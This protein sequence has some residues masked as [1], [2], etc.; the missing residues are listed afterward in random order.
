MKKVFRGGRVLRQGKIEPADLWVY[1]EKI[2]TPQ[3]HADQIVDVQGLILAPGYIDLQ[4]NGGFGVDFS[5][6]PERVLEV[7]QKLPR[8]GVTAFLPTVISSSSDCYPGLLNHLR[9]AM[10]Q[11][12]KKSATALGIHLEG[13]FFNPS[14]SGAHDPQCLQRCERGI[15]A[16]YGSLEDVKMI[17]LAPELEGAL[18]LITALHA[19][20]IL[21]SA[22]HSSA[23][24]IQLDEAIVAG[25]GCATHLYNAMPPFHHRDPGLVGAV[26][27]HP[28]LPFTL[29]A[30]SVHVHPLA[31][32][33]AWRCRPEG[34]ILI[35]DAISAL[36]A[37]A[38]RLGTLEIEVI[39]SK[40]V[41]RGTN[42]LA[43]STHAL[44]SCV[45]FFWESTGCSQAAALE[46]AS[47]KP[48]KLL[49]LAP[50]K[51]TLEQGADAD[52][53]VLDDR[54]HV[55]GCYING[56]EVIQIK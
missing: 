31:I 29:I 42:T 49:G 26:L 1:E 44:D 14:H 11:Q 40:A 36:G 6:T 43:G 52:I 33:I 17:T 27:T 56:Q 4:I 24:T 28:S 35:S 38:A 21:V 10:R 39:D 53:L 37:T 47:L 15:A 13:P 22:G 9:A 19:Q 16:T 45:R 54:L 41:I 48:A 23:N 50:R 12:G 8:Y 25:L 46:A 51:G 18:N 20:G 7:A 30:D 5:T 3:L 55:R 34:V 2:S 32:Q